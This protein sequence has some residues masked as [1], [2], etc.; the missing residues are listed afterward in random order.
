MNPII[1]MIILVALQVSMQGCSLFGPSKGYIYDKD[2]RRAYTEWVPGHSYQ[3]CYTNKK[4]GYKKCKLVYVS[5]YSV[6]HPAWYLLYI[7]SCTLTQLNED[8]H[9]CNNGALYVSQGQYEEYHIRDY[10][11]FSYEDQ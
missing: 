6:Y 4:T 2:M 1:L 7:S 3:S 5:G 9:N 10:V 8:A 11:D